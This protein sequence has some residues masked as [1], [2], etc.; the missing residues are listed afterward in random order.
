MEILELELDSE[1]SASL[2]E[3]LR[4]A[5]KQAIEEGRWEVGEKF[6]T[7]RELARVAGVSV[8]PVYSAVSAL[9]EEGYLDKRAGSGTFVRSLTAAPRRRNGA[10]AIVFGEDRAQH[11]IDTSQPYY[12]SLIAS[13]SEELTRRDLA[14][15]VL[16]YGSLSEANVLD[17]VDG[18]FAIGAITDPLI[19]VSRE[20][21]LPLIRIGA[22]RTPPGV[23][24]VTGNEWQAIVEAVELLH[25][26]G[27]REIGLLHAFSAGVEPPSGVCPRYDAFHS[28]SREL[29]LEPAPRFVWGAGFPDN[30]DLSLVQEFLSQPNRPT[31][32]VCAHDVAAKALYDLAT[33]AGV[34][35][36]DELSVIALSPTVDFGANFS[37]PL[38]TLCGANDRV[39]KLAVAMLDDMLEA[40][41]CEENDG[42][43]VRSR[44]IERASIAER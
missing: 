13:L 20:K 34:A 26:K 17:Q 7:V 32:V 30:V 4:S 21:R 25:A 22:T 12:H 19:E 31:A 18:L 24:F 37:P 23:P 28:A 41:T 3:Q 9:V 6:P 15:R 29:G 1:D 10:V 33:M 27:H 42:L 16:R 38:T 44:L 11:E 5:L 8:S 39:A 2:L 40:G 35:I 14:A 43:L 36:P